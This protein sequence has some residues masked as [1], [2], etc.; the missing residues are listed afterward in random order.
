MLRQDLSTLIRSGLSA[1][2]WHF[3]TEDGRVPGELFLGHGDIRLEREDVPFL[4]TA[5]AAFVE[6]T[7]QGLSSSSRCNRESAGSVAYTANPT[8][9]AAAN[10]A[11]EKVPPVTHHAEVP[12]AATTPAYPYGL[13]EREVEVLR[14]VAAGHSNQKIA[15]E[16]FLSRYTIVRH[17]SNIFGK[18][19]AANRTEAATYANRQGLV[20]ETVG[21]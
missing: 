16:L 1:G 8:N 20:D 19:G 9:S 12:R 5:L 2:R 18:I 14:L 21:T 11:T 17:V 7:S 4:W 10:P 13:S 3:F 6:M 15:D